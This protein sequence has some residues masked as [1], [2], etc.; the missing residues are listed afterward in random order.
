MLVGKELSKHFKVGDVFQ[1]LNKDKS[2]KFKVIGILKENLS[3]F[4][5][6]GVYDIVNTNSY[7]I[8][9]KVVESNLENFDAKIFFGRKDSNIK[10]FKES[11]EKDFNDMNISI[12]VNLV[13][14]N[15]KDVEKGIKTQRSIN[16][17]TFIVVLLFSSVGFISSLLY[18]IN[19]RLSEFGVHL[20]SGGT[21]GDIAARIFI[22]IS[23]QIVISF[24][25]AYIFRVA[26]VPYKME[27]RDLFESI[28]Y[29]V[30]IC[31]SISLVPVT[32]I[33]RINIDQ[34]LRG[35]E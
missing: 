19:K 2:K 31:I 21:I 28:L 18:S 12:Q 14:D 35:R 25:V 5:A 9:P 20:M 34:L 27:I 30:I 29:A 26:Y 23:I 13:D 8:I 33:L 24:I 15:L 17:I 1:G 4:G 3:V 7:F 11:I 32:K 22:E 10:N 16:N 6:T